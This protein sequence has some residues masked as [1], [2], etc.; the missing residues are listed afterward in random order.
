MPTTLRTGPYRF[1][2]YSYDCGEP[3]HSHIDR[4]NMS[5]KFWLDPN[6]SLAENF[7]FPR[8]ELRHI[9]R[10]IRENLETLRN[11]WDAFCSDD[12]AVR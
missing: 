1:Y 2:F 3:R 11:E 4:E 9:E 10:V 7:G 5:A 6:V 8:K 12:T